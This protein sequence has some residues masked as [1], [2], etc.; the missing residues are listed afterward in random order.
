MSGIPQKNYSSVFDLI[1]S[2]LLANETFNRF[3]FNGVKNDIERMKSSLEFQDYHTLLGLLYSSVWDGEQALLHFNNALK[4]QH[5]KSVTLN[6]YGS[7]LIHLGLHHKAYKFFN[8]DLRVDSSDW[9]VLEQKL[10]SEVMALDISSAKLTLQKLKKLN[11]SVEMGDGMDVCG[12]QIEQFE[13]FFSSQNVDNELMVSQFKNVAIK[14]LEIA[15]END[16]VITAQ[17]MHHIESD[18]QLYVQLKVSDVNRSIS[19][20][21]MNDI[22]LSLI[23][24]M[25]DNELDH[26]PLYI[27]Y[28]RGSRS[29]SVN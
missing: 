26:L 24:Y 16:L 19:S 28:S 20:K 27:Q 25:I 13:K 7:T 17:S 2:K 23:D 6:N 29:D 8:S 14:A 11:L 18:E 10:R 9:R 22:N 12:A 5:V 15:A 1:E 21:E 4:C 3:E